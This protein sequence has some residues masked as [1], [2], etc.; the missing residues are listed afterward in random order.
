[1]V[2]DFF[3]KTKKKEKIEPIKKTKRSVP[4]KPIKNIKKKE[5]VNSNY[6]KRKEAY[7]RKYKYSKQSIDFFENKLNSYKEYLNKTI[8]DIR[9]LEEYGQ[10][11]NTS[12]LLNYIEKIKKILVPTLKTLKRIKFTPEKE[13]EY[14]KD[15]KEL[16]S[17]RRFNSS[18]D[19]REHRES[20][21]DL[22]SLLE[23][24]YSSDINQRDFQ[25]VVENIAKLDS[26]FENLKK[27]NMYSNL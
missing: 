23:N 9:K 24:P 22:E 7:L 3:N 12:V 1:M 13:Y 25:V 2:F 14:R 18:Q 26:L 11:K 6:K 15:L 8:R 16:K 27:M 21:A 19:A 10:I 4:K 17:E 20:I 5:T